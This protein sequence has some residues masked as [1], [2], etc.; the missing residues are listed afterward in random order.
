MEFKL[1]EHEGAGLDQL[2]TQ[3]AMPILR[4]IQDGSPI[5][6]KSDPA[7]EEKKIDGA[8]AGDLVFQS[9]E[10]LKEVEAVKVG[11]VKPEEIPF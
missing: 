2:D 1:E 9:T 8:E 3:A 10:A 6:K 4:I 5:V 11:E 7:H